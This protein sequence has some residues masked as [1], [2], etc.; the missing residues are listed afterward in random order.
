MK[1]QEAPSS[2]SKVIKFPSSVTS[3]Q[4]SED[5]FDV[6]FYGLNGGLLKGKTEWS[7]KYSLSEFALLIW[8]SVK[9]WVDVTCTCLIL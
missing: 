3:Y 7:Y 2:I 6:E 8:V 9:H 4:K 5:V 1:L